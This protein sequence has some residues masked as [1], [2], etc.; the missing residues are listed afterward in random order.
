MGGMGM[1][2]EQYYGF[3]RDKMRL[4]ELAEKMGD[5]SIVKTMIEDFKTELKQPTELKN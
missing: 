3:V 4:L 5:W 1:T 2:N